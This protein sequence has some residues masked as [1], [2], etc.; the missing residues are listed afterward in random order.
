MDGE[1]GVDEHCAESVYSSP[2]SL[3]FRRLCLILDPTESKT[4][5]SWHNIVDRKA[6]TV[7]FLQAD[8]DLTKPFVSR[9]VRLSCNTSAGHHEMLEPIVLLDDQEQPTSFVRSILGRS[10]IDS[11]EELTTLLKAVETVDVFSGTDEIVRNAV[12]DFDASCRL[13]LDPAVRKLFAALDKDKYP[14]K[15]PSTVKHSTNTDY[16]NY[17][18]P[19]K[20]TSRRARE[21]ACAQ[22]VDEPETPAQPS[23]AISEEPADVEPVSEEPEIYTINE[24]DDDDWLP[25]GKRKSDGSAVMRGSP[26]AARLSRNISGYQ[27]KKLPALLPKRNP[28]LPTGRFDKVGVP[29]QPSVRVSFPRTTPSPT[30]KPSSVPTKHV[31][32]GISSVFASIRMRHTFSNVV[33]DKLVG[34]SNSP[35]DSARLNQALR[36]PIASSIQ[37]IPKPHKVP[38]GTSVTVSVTDILAQMPSVAT[39]AGTGAGIAS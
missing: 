19:R 15:N 29:E 17:L 10:H 22:Q 6:R 13:Q 2:L 23:P 14:S 16:M 12:D 5:S 36:G 26:L 30:Q 39:V 8:F 7:T 25:P 33:A 11:V 4:P 34:K 27:E 18:S 35:E 9:C 24:S 38:V 21:W 3:D 20:K 37:S 31:K 1:H 32:Y 28:N